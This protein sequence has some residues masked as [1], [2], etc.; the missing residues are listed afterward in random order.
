MPLPEPAP[1]KGR[2]LISAIANPAALLDFLRVLGGDPE[3]KLVDTIGPPERP[4][5]LVIDLAR[6]KALA[7]E[8]RF[9]ETNQLMI[10]PDQPLSL[11][12]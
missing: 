8:Q 3:I 7:L 4:H 1:G 11:P 6:E 9:R 10:E 5:T 2:Y 12:L